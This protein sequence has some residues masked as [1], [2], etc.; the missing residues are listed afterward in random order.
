[1]RID[2]TIRPERSKLTEIAGD[3]SGPKAAPA[4]ADGGAASAPKID[5]HLQPYLDKARQAPEIDMDAVLAARKLLDEGKLDTPD[6]ILRAAQA[7]V[8]MDF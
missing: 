1:M 7:M 5:A 3:S 8:D 4:Q 6:A 2:G